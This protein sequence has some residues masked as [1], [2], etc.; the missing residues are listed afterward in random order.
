MA[1]QHGDGALPAAVPDNPWGL[2]AGLA[3]VGLIA[4]VDLLLGPGPQLNGLFTTPPFVTAVFSGAKRTAIVGVVS[5]GVGIAMGNVGSEFTSSQAFRTGGVI[6]AAVGA[7]ALSVLRQR[8]QRD[9]LALGR[10]ADVAQLAVLRA[11]PEQIG[12]ARV[13]VRYV[14]AS[15]NAHVGGDLYE[16]VRCAAGMRAIV[17]DIRGKGLEAVQLANVIVGAF[18]A[19][20]HDAIDLPDL[21]RSLDAAFLRFDP[22]DEDF[23]TAVIIE[24]RDDGELRVVNCGHPL[25]LLVRGGDREAIVPPAYV[26]PIGLGARPAVATRRLE[27][28]DRVLLLTDGILETRHAGRF[29]DFGANA[30]VAS[31][32][33]PGEALDALVE[34]LFAFSGGHVGD[35]V[36]LLLAEYGGRTRVDPLPTG[37]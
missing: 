8:E 36:A 20:D 23:A 21:A 28:G 32:G 33:T 14:S 29:F 30:A 3:A 6:V 10:I 16:A 34:R 9:M 19:A 15:A 37:R 12:P 27:P 7:V 11:L 4:L 5:V 2:V 22:G 17:G 18:R 1:E 24:L 13:A 25:P 26:P 35:D 31:V